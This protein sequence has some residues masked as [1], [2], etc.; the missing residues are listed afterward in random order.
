MGLK[1]EKEDSRK[2]ARQKKRGPFIKNSAC[3]SIQTYAFARRRRGQTISTFRL[4]HRRQ[5]VSCQSGLACYCQV[6]VDILD[7]SLSPTLCFLYRNWFFQSNSWL[8]VPSRYQL[9]SVGKPPTGP[10]FKKKKDRCMFWRGPRSPC[11]HPTPNTGPFLYCS[12][13]IER[14]Y[15]C[16]PLQRRCLPLKLKSRGQPVTPQKSVSMVCA[17]LFK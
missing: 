4:Y 8:I 13:S 3:V 6:F 14:F 16:A 10:E 9:A 11:H 1:K 2:S 17:P 7:I 5:N 12:A 15:I